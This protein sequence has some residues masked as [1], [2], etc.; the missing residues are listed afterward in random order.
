MDMQDFPKLFRM[1]K[2]SRIRYNELTDRIYVPTPREEWLEHMRRRTVAISNDFE[3]NKTII[4]DIYDAFHKEELPEEYYEEL[5][6]W[7]KDMYL[8]DYEDPFMLEKFLLILIPHY[9]ARGD[10]EHLVF[11]YL[12]AGYAYIEMS[13]I[14]DSHCGRLSVSYYKKVLHYK[15]H[16]GDFQIPENRTYLLTAYCNLV[17]VE[18]ELGHISLEESYEYWLELKE[19]RSNPVFCRFDEENP[20]IPLLSD[21]TLGDFPKSALMLYRKMKCDDQDLFNKLEKITWDYYFRD[22][23]TNTEVFEKRSDAYYRFVWVLYT[24]KLITAEDAFR[25]MNERYQNNKP[26]IVKLSPE[27]RD[28]IGQL[29]NP[30]D[31]MVA[32]LM[33][34]DLPKEEKERFAKKYC[35]D[36]LDTIMHYPRGYDSY[37]LNTSILNIAINNNMISMLS[38]DD[39]KIEFV[40][41]VVVS[42]QLTTYIHSKMVSSIAEMILEVI[43]EEHPEYLVGISGCE[44][45]MEVLAQQEE[46]RKYTRYAALL[47]DIGKN[48]MIDII[49]TENRKLTD[50]EF[51]FLR[52]HPQLGADMLSANP[53]F[54]PYRDI[55]LGHHKRYDGKGGYPTNF[56]NVD[57]VWK[58]IIDL[59]TICDCIDAATDYLGRN[60][61]R[62]KSFGTILGELK[63]G[64]GTW[65]HPGYVALMED[66]I[67]L[68]E[69]LQDLTE[70][71]REIIFYETYQKYF[72]SVEEKT[73]S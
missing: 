70:K 45:V 33:E 42:R 17:R 57:S 56:D 32:V 22:G 1:L 9:E 19:M 69:K 29:L 67:D 27:E 30:V 4:D 58:P 50:H 6:F 53:V 18:P 26:Q 51:E 64:A 36:I 52:M 14:G 41:Q 11:L 8:K 2:E 44:T 46:I 48:A 39:E 3:R 13:R 38:S 43:L 25:K 59:I 73:G 35:K 37:T 34:T 12:C 72:L 15:D 47:H 71:Q 60:Y 10:Y 31:I 54:L 16:F 63:E 40:L 65:Y 20:K 62:A 5:F 68:F 66:S 49:T 55:V 24:E 7:T 21:L 28:P 23:K 61:Q